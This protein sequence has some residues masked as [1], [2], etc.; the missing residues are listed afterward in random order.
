MHTTFEFQPQ[1][2]GAS[3]KIILESLK[4]LENIWNI[5]VDAELGRV[6]FEYMTWA[7]REQV[8]RE[9]HEL[10]Y[11]TINDTHRFDTPEN[12]L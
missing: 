8:R 5:S 11:R 6:S 1:T 3:E 12:H 2:S 4:S 7:D 10:G 9:L